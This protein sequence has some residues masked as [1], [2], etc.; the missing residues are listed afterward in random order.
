MTSTKH[1]NKLWKGVFA[2]GF[3]NALFPVMLA[4]GVAGTTKSSTISDSNTIVDDV[5]KLADSIN[6]NGALVT[7]C[8]VF[9]LFFI[10]LI[11][12]SVSL[13]VKLAKKNESNANTTIEGYNKVMS[14]MSSVL[15]E[16][17]TV[18]SNENIQHVQPPEK[19]EEIEKK[20]EHIT[21][22]LGMAVDESILYKGAAERV[23]EKLNCDRVAIYVFH[24]GNASGYG[25]PFVKMSCIYENTKDGMHTRRARDANVPLH[26]FAEMLSELYKNKEFGASEKDNEWNEGSVS[27]FVS[28]S[29]TKAFYMKAIE[30]DRGIAGFTVCEFNEYLDINA[31]MQKPLL[32]NSLQDMNEA[33]HYI[34]TNQDF[35]EKYK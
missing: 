16:S 28:N 30:G 3:S 12:G 23:I 35:S 9:I 19:K 11:I 34:I 26:V 15:A 17:L 8:A 24:N 32:R 7:I 27:E 1:I 10:L 14:L 21:N 18:R 22:I 29:S 4:T 13:V 6:S 25:L 5:T 2:V 31:S 33:I 20:N